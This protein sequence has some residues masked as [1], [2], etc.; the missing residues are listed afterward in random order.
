MSEAAAAAGWGQDWTPERSAAGDRSPW[1]IIFVISIA[2]FMEVLDV[3]VANVALNHIGGSLSASYDETTWVLT[4]YLIANAIVIPISG[5]L[6]DVI[7]RKRYYMIS[8]ALFAASSLLC[9][10]APNLTFLVV[11]RIF[12]GIGG[13][14]LAP[15]EQAMMADTFPPQQRGMAFAAY[16]IVVI[17]G[18]ILGPTLGGWITDNASWHWVFLINVPIGMLS[19]LLVGMLVDEPA[20][21][22][23]E[24]KARIAGGLKVDWVGFLLVAAGLGFLEVTLDRGQRDDWFSSGGITLSAIASAASLVALIPWELSRE[25]PVVNLRLLGQRNFSIAFLLLMVTGVVVFG[26]TQFIP[27]LLQQVMG[28]TA[29]EAGLALTIGGLATVLVMPVAGFLAGRA[30]PR[31]LLGAGLV[32]QILAIWNMSHLDTDM[33]FW[34]ASEARLFSAV[35]LPF[36]FVTVS[37]LAYVGLKP[38]ENN[39]ASGLMNVARNLG[40]SM[41]ISLVQTLL[42]QR[43]QVHQSQLAETLNQLNPVYN[44]SLSHTAHVLQ[45]QGGAAPAAAT[46]EATGQI[47]QELQRQAAMLS[48]VDAFHALVIVILILTPTIFLL[49]GRP[50]GAPAGPAH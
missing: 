17:V 30:D 50:A 23:R 47:Y 34:H 7:G 6:A 27:Q 3:S 32:I 9:G 29:T 36:M 16:G 38:G 40:G 33:D 15:S 43:E 48:F 46:L 44:Q 39:Q 12:Q 21:L 13:G 37:S 26:T 19:L 14:G 45:F 11:A 31:L 10:L 25:D 8:V 20:V 4:S 5:W 49:R 42:A 18:P 22:T 35:G 28:Y 24:R 41:G 2:T 1:L